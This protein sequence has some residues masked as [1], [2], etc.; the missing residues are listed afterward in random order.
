MFRLVV[1]KWE[2][3]Q[4]DKG[5]TNNTDKV[6]NH[7]PFIEIQSSARPRNGFKFSITS[8]FI[9]SMGAILTFSRDPIITAVWST[10]SVKRGVMPFD[11]DHFKRRLVGVR[12]NQCYKI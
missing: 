2:S 11:D 8:L 10:C 5:Y 7:F 4:N 3:A 1:L 9:Q 6:R 12:Y